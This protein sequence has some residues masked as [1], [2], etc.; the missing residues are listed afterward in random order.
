MGIP[1][2]RMNTAGIE[3][4]GWVQLTG[5]R[6]KLIADNDTLGRDNIG[7]DA[8]NHCEEDRVG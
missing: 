7:P 3:T 1:P 5:C 4:R 6:N 2:Q 8:S